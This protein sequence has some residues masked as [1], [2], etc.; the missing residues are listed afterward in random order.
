MRCS[1]C[2]SHFFASEKRVRDPLLTTLDVW[3]VLTGSP[4]WLPDLLKF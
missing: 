3:F 4:K 2:A 1:N